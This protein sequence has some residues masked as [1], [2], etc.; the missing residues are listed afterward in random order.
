MLCHLLISLPETDKSNL[1][2][3][4]QQLKK[5]KVISC[6]NIYQQ[7]D[8]NK[9]ILESRLEIEA[10]VIKQIE[11][12][13]ANNT[14]VIYDSFYLKRVWRMDFFNR[15][16]ERIPKSIEWF[17]WYFKFDDRKYNEFYL[18]HENIFK[19][20]P[21]IERLPEIKK[22]LLSL[23]KAE[24]FVEICEIKN[25]KNIKLSNKDR[26][27][28][29]N[30]NVD[31]FILSQKRSKSKTSVFHRYSKLI[32]F[33]RLMHLISL[34]I[35]YPALGNLQF[36]HPKMIKK[37][38]GEEKTFT[39]SID[40]ITAIMAQ[41]K[42]K[43]YA[44]RNLITEDLN[45][46]ESHQFLYDNQDLVVQD[47][48]ITVEKIEYD[49][50]FF[51]HYAS[52]IDAFERILTTLKFIS[53]NP[54]IDTEKLT[55]VNPD[56]FEKLSEA[57]QSSHLSQKDKDKKQNL[58]KGTLPRFTY[59]LMEYK[60]ELNKKHIENEELDYNQEL[61]R[62]YWFKRLYNLLE[63]RDNLRKDFQL[64][65]HPY[66]VFPHQTMRKGY[67]FGTGILTEQELKQA[68][69]LVRNQA[70]DIDDLSQLSFLTSFSK[71]LKLLNY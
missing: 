38:F 35:H 10:E 17:G 5:Y 6:N 8:P 57:I 1:I 29:I 21:P 36:E 64:I 30:F 53:L 58:L 70:N 48:P 20:I 47:K 27:K 12:A 24:G 43:I 61:N 44:E 69:D 42:G 55:L 14:P 26:E 45:F 54:F 52:N 9:S 39:D 40:E 34:L 62:N 51:T 67:F 49:D 3:K 28:I 7:L 56:S 65:I 13:I 4:L 16:K 22:K 15:V 59:K 37:I 25:E 33:N 41:L 2:Q 63:C 66:Q 23:S 68:F 50:Y 71:F 11:E 32:D 19:T 46:L 60:E 31:K 18:K